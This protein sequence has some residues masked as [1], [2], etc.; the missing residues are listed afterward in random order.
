MTTR[1]L[2]YDDSDL[3]E[4]EEMTYG[5]GTSL[6]ARVFRVGDFTFDHD[7]DDE[8]YI[9]NLILAQLAWL[10]YLRSNS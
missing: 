4:V 2:H 3:P 1:V 8:D 10:R 5:D 9:E 6:Q 7:D